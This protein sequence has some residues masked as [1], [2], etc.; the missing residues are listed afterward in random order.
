MRREFF[1][2][3]TWFEGCRVSVVLPRC[4]VLPSLVVTGRPNY[5]WQT[6]FLA[7]ASLVSQKQKTFHI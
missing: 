2:N 3:L 7:N 1:V 4:F 5:T 6:K